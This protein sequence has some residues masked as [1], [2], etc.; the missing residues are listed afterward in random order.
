MMRLLKLIAPSSFQ[1]T[2]QEGGT[3]TELSSLTELKRNSLNLGRLRQ[4]ELIGQSF[5][6]WEL[7]KETVLEICKGAFPIQ[8]SNNNRDI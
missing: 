8:S 7:Y 3:Q 6:E 2:D 4:L 1:A 5:R